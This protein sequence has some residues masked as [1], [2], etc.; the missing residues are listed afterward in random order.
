MV[1][2]YRDIF[3]WGDPKHNEIVDKQKFELLCGL[4]GTGGLDY[5]DR[6][7]L[8]EEE[9]K[10]EKKSIL[11]EETLDNLRGIVGADNVSVND[12]DRAS[13]AYGKFYLDLIML[14]LGRIPTPPD[15]VVFPRNEND[16]IAI[17]DFCNNERIP[18]TPFGGHS[19]VSRG[20]ETPKG[21]ISLDMTRHMNGVIK[22]NEENYSVTVQPGIYG[23]DLENYL[24]NFKT[25]YTCGHFPQSFE[26]ST[27][28]GW[29]V[30]RGAGQAS[31]GYGKIE[32]IVLSL[33]VVTPAGVIATKDYPAAAIG[34]D[35]NNIFIGSEGT[36]G[37]VTEVT[38]KIRNY[39]PENT[40][41]TSFVFKDFPS[42]VAAMKECMQ[43]EFGKPHLFRISDSEE[44][45]VAFQ[46][47]G[48]S[49]SF[50]D[51]VLQVLG[52]MP[53]ERCLMFVSIEGDKAYTRFVASRIKKIAKK[54]KGFRTGSGPAEKWLEQRYSSSYLRDPLMDLGL[55]TDTLETAVTWENLI[56]L[57]EAGRKYVKSR[58]NTICMVHISHVYENGANLYFT[59]L[60]PV[61]K[62]DD[63]DDFKEFHTGLINTIHEN[64]GS[65]SHHHGIGRMLGPWMSSEIGENALS[66]LKS[67]KKHLDPNGI[68]NPGGTLGLDD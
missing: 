43:S 8:G 29:T 3:R 58:P 49:G 67:I 62:G 35:I 20:V 60:S 2:T 13:H 44:T 24:N 26:F 23:P 33:R 11:P 41:L 36:L 5:E 15:A 64:N 9:I 55:M 18:I 54:Y 52:Y 25:G 27:A 42:A 16:V 51:K 6:Y 48:K 38:M 50:S 68:M 22:V 47:G 21:G 30:T 37:V 63:I 19:S 14:R 46:S 28:G 1:K 39:R 57:W 53:N 17:V 66:L 12:F 7:L 10:L 34:P 65:L 31:T 40:T 61:K 59:F 56:P 4:L 32:D 45:E